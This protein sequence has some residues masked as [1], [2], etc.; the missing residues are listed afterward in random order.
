MYMNR[1]IY[2]LQF[3]RLITVDTRVDAM[4][5]IND[6]SRELHIKTS[7]YFNSGEPVEVLARL[8]AEAKYRLFTQ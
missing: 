4:E 2:C 3:L 6:L 1:L 7:K 5:D 8:I